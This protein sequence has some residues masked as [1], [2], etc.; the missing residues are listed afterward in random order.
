VKTLAV[1]ILV[2]LGALPA[3]ADVSK[4]DIK[5]LIDAKMSDTVIVSYIK[6]NAPVRMTP[7]DL[8]LLKSAGATEA[9]LTALVQYMT[10]QN[11]VVPE[12]P[13]ATTTL[14][15]DPYYGYGYPYTYWGWGW[16]YYGYYGY[17]H[18]YYGH[19]YY[20]PG[21]VHP[22]YVHHPG[23]VVR[24]GPVRGGGGGGHGGGGHGGHR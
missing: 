12:Q 21:Y 3:M 17:G 5:K 18:G 1:A 6:T 20:H 19:G 10:P 4:A 2:C 8:V 13:V 11:E 22:G 23:P 9:V 16:P 7:T 15:V 24:P 14:Y